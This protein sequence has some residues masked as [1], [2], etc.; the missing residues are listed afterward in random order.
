MFCGAFLSRQTNFL[1]FSIKIGT[2]PNLPW[3]GLCRQAKVIQYNLLGVLSF[4]QIFCLFLDDCLGRQSQWMLLM[5]CRWHWVLTQ[6]HAPDLK[7]ELNI[8][9][10]LTL[11]HPLD[12]PICAKDIMVT[13][14]LL[15]VMG[16]MGSL[17][18]GSSILGFGWGDKGWLLYFSYFL[19]WFCAVV[20][21]SLM[22]GTYSLFCLFHCPFFAFFVSGPFNQTLLMHGNCCVCF[23]NYFR[24]QFSDL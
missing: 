2:Q 13:V 12:C 5:S 18:G 17:G 8:T 6:G 3:L 23:V 16:R 24:S 1:G 11:P 14:S 4:F 19:F 9:S 22:A 10:F 20:N 21:C 7:C 15:Q